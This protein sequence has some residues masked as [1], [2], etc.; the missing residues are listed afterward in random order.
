MEEVTKWLIASTAGNNLFLINTFAR[1]PVM[2]N[3]NKGKVLLT[4]E[5]QFPQKD[6][7]L[8]KGAK[9]F[10][11]VSDIAESITANMCFVREASRAQKREPSPSNATIAALNLQDK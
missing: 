11:L 5:N 3:G 2:V 8:S 4:N 10:T 9:L 6:I 7:V 1:P